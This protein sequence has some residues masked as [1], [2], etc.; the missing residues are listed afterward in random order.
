MYGGL[1][2]STPQH[3]TSA[4]SHAHIMAEHIAATAHLVSAYRY[5]RQY[6]YSK[7]RFS[8]DIYISG[9]YKLD[10]I[11]VSERDSVQLSGDK[12]RDMNWPLPRDRET[13][14]RYARGGFTSRA[15]A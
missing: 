14:A 1:W 13:G 10:F 12:I 11:E 15:R 9:G 6:F 7:R 4:Q 2:Q 5:D 3:S 8:S